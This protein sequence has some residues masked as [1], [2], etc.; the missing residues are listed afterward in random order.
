MVV[1]QLA[2]VLMMLIDGIRRH[3]EDKLFWARMKEEQEGM[4][5]YTKAQVELCK[6][7]LAKGVPDKNEQPETRD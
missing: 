2:L 5:A 3:K 4:L 7:E 1:I 6:R